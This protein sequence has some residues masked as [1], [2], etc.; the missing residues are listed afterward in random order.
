MK[1][2]NLKLKPVSRVSVVESVTERVLALITSG[3]VKPGERLPP[4]YELAQQ[5]GVG[6][7]SVREALR[8]L[9]ILGLVEA[10]TGRGTVVMATRPIPSGSDLPRAIM[11]WGLLD[12]FEVRILLETRG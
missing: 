7:S 8:S 12:T 1:E 11:K 3:E 10:R 9:L 5:L 2:R 4:E 6:R